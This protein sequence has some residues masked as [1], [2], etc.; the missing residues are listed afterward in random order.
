M[1][2]IGN[3]VEKT[4]ILPHVSQSLSRSQSQQ[5]KKAPKGTVS[6]Q[7]F[8]DRL[9]LCWSYH[10]KRY[11]LYVGLPDSKINRV[12]AEQKARQIEGDMATGNF[13]SSLRKYKPEYQQQAL[14]I[15]AIA[16]FERFMVHKAKEVT[17]RTMQ[18]Y[19]ATLGYLKSFFG[20][21]VAE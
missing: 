4:S 10:G 6:V 16:R 2:R 21:R 3:A 9:R 18:K 8:K 19:R 5:R 20:D 1:T 12:V 7:V 17:P 13:D 11:F 14:R 15:S